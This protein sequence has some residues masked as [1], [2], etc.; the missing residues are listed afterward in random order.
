[1]PGI[2][3]ERFGKVKYDDRITSVYMGKYV[4]LSKE[5]QVPENMVFKDFVK[6]ILLPKIG[7]LIAH[8]TTFGMLSS[9]KLND[10][11]NKELFFNKWLDEN[12]HLKGKISFAEFNEVQQIQLK[13]VIQE[14]RVL[15]LFAGLSVLMLGSWDGDD[16]PDYKRYLLTRKL[17]SLLFKT[18]QELAFNYSP[19]SFSAMIKSPLP[20]LGLVSDAYKTIANT[21]DEVFDLAFGEE[22][23]IGGQKKDKLG[24]MSQTVKWAPGLGG[25]LRFIDFFNSDTQYINNNSQ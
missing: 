22:R 11:H 6:K 18:Q 25:F 2:M 3:F 9:T 5:F 15:L 19:V 14:L 23:L 4:A 12:Q 24:P 20:V 1:M 10:V 21:F 17:A 8:I 16:D 13:S 7:K